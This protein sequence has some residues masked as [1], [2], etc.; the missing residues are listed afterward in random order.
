MVLLSNDVANWNQYIM[1]K[2][3]L[4][5]YFDKV[6]ISA[7]A[8]YGKPDR[9]IFE[10]ALDEIKEEPS[11]C[12]FVDN[13]VANLLTAGELGMIPVLFNRDH[14]EYNGLQ[15]KSFMELSEVIKRYFNGQ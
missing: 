8:G 7:I 9:T 15:V 10:I 5:Q 11:D 2:Y 6:I 13:S 12:V 4:N 14:V 3:E 1:E